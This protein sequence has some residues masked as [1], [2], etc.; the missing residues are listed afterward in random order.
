M[1]HGVARLIFTNSRGYAALTPGCDIARLQRAGG[2]RHIV[3]RLDY[4]IHI[5]TLAISR[6]SLLFTIHYSL[7]LTL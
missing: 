7:T 6:A 4:M 3:A 2:M 5:L 1:R